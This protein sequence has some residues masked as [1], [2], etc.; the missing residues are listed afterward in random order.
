[1]ESTGQFVLLMLAS[2][3]GPL[4]AVCV[5]CVRVTQCQGVVGV[6]G[7]NAGNVDTHGRPFLGLHQWSSTGAVP[8]L[9]AMA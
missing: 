4:V 6:R 1:M 8:L 3:S 7:S 9:C 5:G 2:L